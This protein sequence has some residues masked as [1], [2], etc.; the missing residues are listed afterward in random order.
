MPARPAYQPFQA[1]LVQCPRILCTLDQC[2]SHLFPH[3]ALPAPVHVG[4]NQQATVPTSAT[5][6]STR[7]ATGMSSHTVRVLDGCATRSD[8]S[9]PAP[10]APYSC[11][12][13]ATLTAFAFAIRTA[14]APTGYP[15]STTGSGRCA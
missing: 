11:T 9:S 2:L 12:S 10:G 6:Y 13:R 1:S 4:M 3:N 5:T 15:A 8:A 7:N 14:P